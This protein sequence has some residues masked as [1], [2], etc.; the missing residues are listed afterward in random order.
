MCSMICEGRN[1]FPCPPAHFPT[2]KSRWQCANGCTFLL[3]RS[4]CASDAIFPAVRQSN[5]K[6]LLLYLYTSVGAYALLNYEQ[7]CKHPRKAF[8]NK[9]FK[10]LIYTV[11]I[12]SIMQE[13]RFGPNVLCKNHITPP[14]LPTQPTNQWKLQSLLILNKSLKVWMHVLLKEYR[15]PKL[16]LQESHYFELLSCELTYSS[17]KW[18]TV[19][20][21]HLRTVSILKFLLTATQGSGSVWQMIGRTE[22]ASVRERGELKKTH[23]HLSNGAQVKQ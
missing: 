7:H 16:E 19:G 20:V 1:F 21:E 23:T 2:H 8:L 6:C 13:Q 18:K 5:I 17:L 22:E 11:H 15:D 12:C 3:G 10:T 4:F 14:P 9:Y